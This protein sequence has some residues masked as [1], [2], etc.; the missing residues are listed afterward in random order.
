MLSFCLLLSFSQV[1]GSLYLKCVFFHLFC[2]CE[3]KCNLFLSCSFHF[4]FM[5][6][7]CPFMILSFCIIFL[8][9]SFHV[10]LMFHY[11][12]FMFL[13]FSFHVPLINVALYSFHV[14]FMFVSSGIHVPSFSVAIYQTYKSSKGDMFKPIRWI[15]AQKLAFS[16]YVVI[17]FVIVLLPFGRPVQVAIF[18]VHEH[19]HV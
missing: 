17:V 10:P 8:S 9:C 12:L 1:V 6:Y 19:V 18:R 11:V 2:G 13:S 5:L 3:S 14:P 15:S 16:S 7:S 4:D